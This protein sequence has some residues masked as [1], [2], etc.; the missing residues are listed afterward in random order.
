[1]AE[2]DFGAYDFRNNSM[3]A[4]DAYRL[5]KS[6]SE[7]YGGDKK[8]IVGN[9][10]RKHSETIKNALIDGLTDYGTEV[11]YIG[12][13]PTDMVAHQTNKQDSM[14]GVAVTASHMPPDYRGLKPLNG[15]GRIFDEEELDQVLT[16]YEDF[17][18]TKKDYNTWQ[19][20]LTTDWFN[21][22]YNIAEEVHADY[23]S[24]AVDRYHDLFDEDL[25]GI[26][27]AVDSGNGVGTLTLPRL[28][29]ELG[30]NNDDLYAVN[31]ELDP[32]FSGRGPD[33]TKSALEGL[34]NTISEEN[35]DLGIAL[36]GDADR[37]V[38]VNENSRKVIGDESLS[39]LSKKYLEETPETR[40]I[41]GIVSSANASQILEDCI[42][43]ERRDEGPLG[44]V[45]YQPVGAVFT[46][47]KALESEKIVFGG[48]PNGH[49]LDP[50]FVPYD[51]GTVAGSIMAGVV[52]ESQ[53]LSSLQDALPSYEIEKA[54]WEVDDK[55]AAMKALKQQFNT[56]NLQGVH[57]ADITNEK[58]IAATQANDK[59]IFRP[60]GNEPVIRV[61]V[62]RRSPAE[63]LDKLMYGTEQILGE[64]E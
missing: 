52:Q 58:T 32:E 28:L 5:G 11:K 53:E 46:A 47:K 45:S 23:I 4:N 30:V 40:D 16:N 20:D 43:G 13:A 42:T 18:N 39:I 55:D 6:L 9:D 12:L 62:E 57:R 31:Q 26:K 2:H 49:L 22:S 59:I 48:Q 61:T 29:S 50:D 3:D 37:A 41:Y 56:L 21:G 36:D 27:V 19:T 7:F 38:F 54:N 10:H 17:T 15:Q 63:M 33:P 8:V 1:M 35:A 14:G 60:S 34:K 44:T 51:S 64:D 25:S 24:D